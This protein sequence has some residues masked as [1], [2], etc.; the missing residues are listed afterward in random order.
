MDN[1]IEMLVTEMH[2]YRIDNVITDPDLIK[3]QCLEQKC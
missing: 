1:S 3:V 2:S